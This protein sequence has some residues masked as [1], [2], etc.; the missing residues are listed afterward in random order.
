MPAAVTKAYCG[1]SAS[2]SA[3]DTVQ[4]TKLRSDNER[5]IAEN[6][7]LNEL[8][9]GKQ[10]LMHAFEE[11]KKKSA[12]V[13]F[14]SEQRE[15]EIMSLKATEFEL[16]EHLKKLTASVETHGSLTARCEDQQL[17]I[18]K[19]QKD[20]ALLS[21]KNEALTCSLESNSRLLE[22]H[23]SQNKQLSEEYKRL[24][25]ENKALL[26]EKEKLVVE[27]K[28]L[29]A[30]SRELRSVKSENVEY[31]IALR[32]LGSDIE[33]F[34]E[35]IVRLSA[36]TDQHKS[37]LEKSKHRE[38]A[39]VTE[40]ENTRIEHQRAI[41][42]LSFD[43]TSYVEKLT[44]LYANQRRESEQQFQGLIHKKGEDHESTKRALSDLATFRDKIERDYASQ[45]SK[46]S[47]RVLPSA[48]KTN[49]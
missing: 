24:E 14:V 16:R 38:L 35:Q 13:S 48:Q 12:E 30:R 5:L 49:V 31:A 25:I 8:L 3:S 42:K 15:E 10:S 22:T 41:E 29:E 23:V 39:T 45:V 17:E 20:H 6:K 7:K 34:K 21:E 27:R 46:G 9:R 40:L 32:A 43:H 11:E 44:T 19:L 37:A 1:E 4:D 33:S 36:Q 47:G 28:E 2:A 18:E 26:S